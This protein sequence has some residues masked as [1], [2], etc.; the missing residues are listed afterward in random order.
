MAF[1]VYSWN[2]LENQIW[3]VRIAD[4]GSSMSV[5]LFSSLVDAEAD[6]NP[7]ATGVTAGFGVSSVAFSSG[8]EK[9]NDALDWHIKVNG[10]DGDPTEIIR[11]NRFVEG[12]EISHAIFRNIE[13]ARIRATE[14]VD[15]H[16]M[17]VKNRTIDLAEHI[18]TLEPG[19]VAQLS[20]EV[21]NRSTLAWVSRVSIVYSLSD[22][23]TSFLGNKVELHEWS[24]LRR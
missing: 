17:M 21:R 15:L 2:V 23:G 4:A 8:V 18:P 24:Q 11:V 7:V 5:K 9:F 10:Q 3:F 16:S 1:S 19:V 22:D 6:Q 20:N 13:L 14:E 12:D